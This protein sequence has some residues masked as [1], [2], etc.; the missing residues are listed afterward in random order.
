MIKINL[1]VISLV[2]I[3]AFSQAS[4]IDGT[5]K[6]CNDCHG[7]KGVS[8]DADM[9]SIA[10]F[11]QTTISDMLIAYAD[12]T[13]VARSSKFRHGDTQRPETNMLTIVK[14]L[15]E[16]HIEAIATYYSE[17]KFIPAN[18]TFDLDLATKGK[19]LH[20]VQCTKCHEKGGSSADDDTGILAGQW[21]PYLA[22][23]I[24]DYRSGERETEDGMKKKLDK[25]SE[26]QIKELI[27]F[28]ASQQ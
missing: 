12:E 16:E 20:K 9:P 17:Q 27:H 15:S 21:M 11:S 13:R 14:E 8:S 7:P 1:L 10:G 6:I 3:S 2:L 25:L 28:Y 19:K 18:Q 26:T 23:T 4:S 24:K 5:I 22:Q